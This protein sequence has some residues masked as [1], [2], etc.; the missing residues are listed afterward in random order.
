MFP[1]EALEASGYN[2]VSVTEANE[3]ST[4]LYFQK[5]YQGA[6]DKTSP[7][8]D[9]VLDIFE[10]PILFDDLSHMPLQGGWREPSTEEP[11]GS[12]LYHSVQVVKKMSKFGG[13]V[14]VL[15]HPT[16]EWEG[17]SAI[18]K[19]EWQEGLF[20]HT[21]DYSAGVTFSDIGDFARGRNQVHLDISPP[22]LFTVQS[23][24]RTVRIRMNPAMP[25][26]GLTLEIPRSWNFVSATP[27]LAMEL[28]PSL[29]V[30]N[31]QHQILV[32]EHLTEDVDIVFYS[33]DNQW[34]S[35]LSY[36]YV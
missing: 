33:P 7:N 13:I 25:V 29:V 31:D 18:D 19:L 23:L 12:M 16:D 30:H 1:D 4:H 10:F 6:T 8:Q 15:S 14:V 20:E 21:L 26:K 9:A 35:S 3:V 5:T 2:Y 27:A 24:A 28:R 11:K 22:Y 34:Y 36:L 17:Y 32:I